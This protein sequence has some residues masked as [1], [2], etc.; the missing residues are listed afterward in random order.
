[1]RSVEKGC[2]FISFS[3][4]K[5]EGDH[6]QEE[7]W[8]TDAIVIAIDCS[9]RMY[10]AADS[11]EEQL[12]SFLQSSLKAVLEIMHRKVICSDSDMVSIL[13]FGSSAQRNDLGHESIYV[14]Y[15]HLEFKINSSDK[16]SKC[17]ALRE[18]CSS[19]H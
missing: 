14:L 12:A 6:Y 11:D 18:Y 1:M 3:M 9:P 4:S 7:R 8:G 19:S 13:L 5:A 16:I 17:L 10:E 2:F 15:S